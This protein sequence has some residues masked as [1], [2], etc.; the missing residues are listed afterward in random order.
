MWTSSGWQQRLL[1]YK[2]E[3]MSCI[4]PGKVL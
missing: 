4:S 2:S 3:A 1:H